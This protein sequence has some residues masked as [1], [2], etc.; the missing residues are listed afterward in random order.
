MNS[1]SIE[2]AASP[3]LSVPDIFEVAVPVARSAERT[4]ESV[5]FATALWISFGLWTIADACSGR[6]AAVRSGRSGARTEGRGRTG[7]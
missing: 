2:S 6:A 1:S 3:L 7:S 4:R 5:P